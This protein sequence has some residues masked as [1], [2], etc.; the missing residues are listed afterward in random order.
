MASA[1]TGRAERR[2]ENRP[3]PPEGDAG[4]GAKLQ[5]DLIALFNG[6]DE[7]RQV[8]RRL[9]GAVPLNRDW[10]EFSVPL[11]PSS[12]PPEGQRYLSLRFSGAGTVEIEFCR[13]EDPVVAA[14][15]LASA[16]SF[17]SKLV[18]GFRRT[19]PAAAGEHDPR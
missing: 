11:R 4:R 18:T 1:G 3:R 10:H 14:R 9:I 6:N 5:L 8:D 12:T 7:Q 19:A 16:K 17:A 2:R 13:I 15:V